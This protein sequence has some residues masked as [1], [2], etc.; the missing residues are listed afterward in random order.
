MSWSVTKK[1]VPG[2]VSTYRELICDLIT[3]IATLPTSVAAGSTCY[4]SENGATYVLETDGDWVVK[5][6][7]KGGVSISSLNDTTITSPANGDVLSYDAESE[8]WTNQPSALFIVNVSYDTDTS[9]ATC[10]KTYAEI[11]AA[12]SAGQI[13][14]VNS[15]YAGS[16]FL[17]S[18]TNELGTDGFGSCHNY[19]MNDDPDDY[20]EVF[21]FFISDSDEVSVTIKDYTLTLA[22]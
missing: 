6:S 18:A 10:D 3:D 19:V 4:C 9:T 11:N 1:Y 2:K 13:P 16:A 7:S 5:G 8:K 15:D 14:V 22:E 17:V 12:V 20:L 21:K